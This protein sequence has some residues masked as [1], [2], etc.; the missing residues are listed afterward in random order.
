MARRR[1]SPEEGIE[2]IQTEL[3]KLNPGQLYKVLRG[4]IKRAMVYTADRVV[5]GQ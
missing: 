3:E 5:R 2:E 1:K 4:S